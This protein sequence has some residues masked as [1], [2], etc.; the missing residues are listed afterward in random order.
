MI[1][2]ALT[3][4]DKNN[5]FFTLLLGLIESSRLKA[6]EKS[7]QCMRR[8]LMHH[9]SKKLHNYKFDESD[10]STVAQYIESRMD[11]EHVT[12][13]TIEQYIQLMENVTG[14]DCFEGGEL[15]IRLFAEMEKVNVAIYEE[16]VPNEGEDGEEVDG[17]SSSN[18]NKHVSYKR[19]EFFG[20]D[21]NDR[22]TIHLRRERNNGGSNPRAY[23]GTEVRPP[24]YHYTLIT[25]KLKGVMDS[26]QAFNLHDL[27]VLYGLVS[28][29]LPERNGKVVE[30]NPVLDII[31]WL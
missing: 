5:L 13:D 8:E 9:L 25:S 4:N 6:G 19:V 31:A 27:K 22:T 3:R 17:V 24:K 29:Y 20:T 2:T 23:Q 12:E 11:V 7:V 1:Y 28:K 14:D 15:E 21:E 18:S 30:F 16:V 10:T 26:L